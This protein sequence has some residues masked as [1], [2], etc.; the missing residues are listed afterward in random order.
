MIKIGKLLKV[1]LICPGI[2]STVSCK[3]PQQD[4]FDIEQE[5]EKQIEED[6]FEKI[7]DRA[8]SDVKEFH[9]FD[10]THIDIANPENPYSNPEI[11]LTGFIISSSEHGRQRGTVTY[12]VSKDSYEFAKEIKETREQSDK[13]GYFN[14]DFAYQRYGDSLNILKLILDDSKTEL[15]S[16]YNNEENDFIYKGKWGSLFVNYNPTEEKREEW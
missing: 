6:I 8:I 16:V 15:W 3:E 11:I 10:L 1:A 13:D 9:S 4:L 14:G 12:L 7:N 2:F 5:I